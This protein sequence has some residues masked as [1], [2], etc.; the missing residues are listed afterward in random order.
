MLVKSKQ[1]LRT[2]FKSIRNGIDKKNR[3]DYDSRMF[4]TLINSDLYQNS[5]L[6]LIYVSFGSE[7]D[8]RNIIEHSL[9]TGKRVAVPYC[10]GK[11]MVF[12]EIKSLNELISGRFGIP[13]VNTGYNLPV[14]SFDNS[15]C[16]VPGVC[17]DL[18]GNRIGYG[19]GFY[20]RFLKD[21]KIKTFA[22]TYGRCITN[23]VPCEPHDIRINY[24]IT[25]NYIRET[26][27]K[28]ASTYE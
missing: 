1:N 16:I 17:F 11:E 23:H 2:L 7:A 22:L 21:N 28:E 15:L 19:G 3:A 5:A 14:D 6:I 9:R 27:Y 25:E 13:T 10:N 8:T 24:I 18:Y 4:T 12:Y 26:L 20:D